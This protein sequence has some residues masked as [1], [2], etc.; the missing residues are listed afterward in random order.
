MRARSLLAVLT[1]ILVLFLLITAAQQHETAPSANPDAEK[2]ARSSSTDSELA[3]QSRE[4]A[5]ESDE[6]QFKHSSSVQFLARI[7]GLS[8]E[9]AYWL[10]VL[11]NF[12]IIAGAIIWISRKNLPS[13]FR[14][15]T[16]S[17]QKA[18]QEARKASEDANRRLSEIETRLSRLD[19]E[20]RQM[21]AAAEKEA[22]AEEER[23]KAAAAEDARKIVE[24]A[25]QEIAAAARAARRD[26][27]AYAADLAVSLA[28]KQI[29]VDTTTD[30]M[31]V[32]N[33]S[34]QLSTSN[35]SGPKSGEGGR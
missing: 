4:A 30:Q 19:V 28:A 1:S 10:S 33:F 15:R 35:G 26:L 27:T 2:S 14:N 12:A 6:E 29:K 23:I 22:A 31:L 25:E 32:R 11:L 9:H 13:V 18:M 8:L 17:I 24:L 16:A 20:I 7:T 34:D 5:G 21:A 3:K